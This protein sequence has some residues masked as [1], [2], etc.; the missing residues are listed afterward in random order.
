MTISAVDLAAIVA[1]LDVDGVTVYDLDQV[2]QAIDQRSCPC[3][4]PIPDKFLILED[5]EQITLGPDGTW[6]Y[7]YLVTYRFVQGPAGKERKAAKKLPDKTDNYIALIKAI[8]RNAQLLGGNTHVKPAS[9][10]EWGILKDS[11]NAD[12]E[13]ADL[14]IRI[15]EYSGN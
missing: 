14:Q 12:Y 15:T 13:A 11:S 5:A 8:C 9:T 3:A 4:Y 6:K 10:P 2:P 7:V 1:N